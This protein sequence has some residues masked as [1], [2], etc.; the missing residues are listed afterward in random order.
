MGSHRLP[1]GLFLLLLLFG[2][3]PGQ[4]QFEVFTVGCLL[5]LVICLPLTY[6]VAQRRG[7]SKKRTLFWLASV[8]FLA[9]PSHCRS[10]L[11]TSGFTEL[12]AHRA[13]TLDAWTW[14][15]ANIVEPIGR[16]QQVKELRFEMSRI[17]RW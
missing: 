8:L 15:S 6:F 9:L 3:E 1:S 10:L 17:S 5:G 7:L 4:G 14:N 16:L 13:I 12:A 11:S 2:G